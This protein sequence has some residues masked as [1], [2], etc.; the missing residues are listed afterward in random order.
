MHTYLHCPAVT[1]ATRYAMGP[2]GLNA[3]KGPSFAVPLSGGPWCQRE[4][5]FI[6][7]THTH[8]T[9]CTA[10]PPLSSLLISLVNEIAWLCSS[11]TVKC[12]EKGS[13]VQN[14]M[15]HNWL[16]RGVISWLNREVCE[17]KWG[18]FHALVRYGSQIV[19]WAPFR[20]GDVKFWALFTQENKR[21]V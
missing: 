13:L 7:Q 10:P 11:I 14:F 20:A 21:P 6:S 12:K 4:I 17:E 15:I 16:N 5:T 8:T 2:S 1:V 3:Q 18:L 19:W 9:Q